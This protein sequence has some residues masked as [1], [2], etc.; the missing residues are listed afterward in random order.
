MKLRQAQTSA[1]YLLPDPGELD[2]R[3]SIRQRVDSPSDDMG[4]EPT[5]PVQFPA[6]AKVV[7]SSATTYQET[8]QTDNVI[9]H[10]ITIRWR[11]GITSDFEVVQGDQVFRVKR[12]RDLNS[13]RRFLLLECTELGVLSVTAGGN[14]NGNSLFS[15]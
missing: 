15:R 10:Y 7:Q 5:Y 4:T 8:A 9:T 6:W 13:K 3:V 12:A 14:S 11:S 2:K 1:T